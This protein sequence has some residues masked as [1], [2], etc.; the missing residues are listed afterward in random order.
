MGHWKSCS[1]IG[2]SKAEARKFYKISSAPYNNPHAKLTKYFF[3]IVIELLT[4][5]R[6]NHAGRKKWRPEYKNESFS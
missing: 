6:N 4:V 2:I 5:Y 3:K 1:D